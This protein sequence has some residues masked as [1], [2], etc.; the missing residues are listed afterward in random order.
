MAKTPENLFRLLDVDACGILYLDDLKSLKAKLDPSMLPLVER[1]LHTHIFS[2]RSF[3]M[4]EEEFVQGFFALDLLPQAVPPPSA[5]SASGNSDFHSAVSSALEAAFRR[6]EAGRLEA[7][8]GGDLSASRIESVTEDCDS[9]LGD[10]LK[11]LQELEAN[12]ELQRAQRT[13]QANGRYGR[14]I[15]D[16]RM[17]NSPVSNYN[18][19]ELKLLFMKRKPP[20]QTAKSSCPRPTKSRSIAPAERSAKLRNSEM[21]PLTKLLEV[22]RAHLRLSQGRCV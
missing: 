15:V 16:L 4:T 8:E 13:K 5:Q 14:P 9:D 2:N 19:E 11:V 17:L 10:T 18:Q 12:T 3:L 20:P 1:V 6:N 21:M 22:R 7:T